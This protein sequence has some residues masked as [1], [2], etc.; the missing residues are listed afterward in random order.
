MTSRPELRAAGLRA[1]VGGLPARNPVWVGSSEL[2]MSLAG[3]KACVDAGAGAVIAKSVNESEAARRQLSIAEYVFTDESHAARA[4]GTA[5]LGDGL[6]NR[7]GL[8]QVE[9][10]QWLETL[11]AAQAYAAARD[12]AVIGSV[13]VAEAAPAARIAAELAT[14]V[15]AIEL[16]V[17]APHGREAAAGAVRQLTEAGSVARTVA[18]VRAAVPVPLLVKLPGQASDV[19]ALADAAYRAGAD[20]VTLVGRYPGFLPDLATGGAVMGSWGAWGS[21]GCL[22]MSLYWVSKAALRFGSSASIVGT[23]GARTAADVARFLASGARAVELVT[24]VWI[25]GPQVIREILTGLQTYLDETG[26]T[27]PSLIGAAAR[28]AKPY[29]A[30]EPAGPPPRPWSTRSARTG[31]ASEPGRADRSRPVP[32]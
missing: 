20:A 24:A 7:S 13:T 23:N 1:D 22:P 5:R 2:T 31:S 10:P 17:G 11:V 18:E 15:P 25:A 12:S 28:Q 16:N 26:R 21:P 9:L 19:L 32:W 3:I 6:L 29:A 30:I 8:A 27:L 14:V 4:D